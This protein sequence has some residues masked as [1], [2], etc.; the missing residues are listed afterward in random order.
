MFV[1]VV[2][3]MTLIRPEEQRAT[4]V[5]FVMVFLLMASYFVLRPVRDAM[6]SDW[7]DA[8]V[9]LLWNIQFFLSAGL[10]TLYSLMVSRLAFRWVVPAV[11]GGFAASFFLFFLATPRLADPTLAEKAFY[12][13]VAAFSLFNL[14]VFWSFMAD[15]FRREQGQRLFAII[16]AGASAGA[17]AGPSIPAL[18]A[19]SLGIDALMLIASLGLLLVI[20]LI[21]Y[22][23]RLKPT[24]LGNRSMRADLA[25]Q[26]IGGQWW[27]GFRDVVQ[28]RYLL[29]IA[30]F[31]TLYVFI[32]SFVYF[33]QKNLLAAYSRPERA[34]ILGAIDWVVNTLTFVFAFFVTGRVVQRLGMAF[35][36]AVVPVIV[37]IGLLVLAFAPI[38]MVL[39]AL[40]VARR[41]GNYAVT[42]P[43]RELLFTEVS[44]DERFKA[45]A[46]IDVVVHRGGDA[47]SGSLFALLTEGMGFGLA[48][49]ALI[50]AAI[51]GIWS[52]LAL[53]LGRLFDQTG[54]VSDRPETDQDITTLG[55]AAPIPKP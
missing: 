4:A 17:I 39:L 30:V 38:I 35:T 8:E 49:V 51:A 34:Q 28:N 19:D 46:V 41:V 44:T 5:S 31:I 54:R 37:A 42:R 6:A 13:W 24:A 10:V 48:A 21:F 12:L 32:G 53:F 11:Y 26:R 45:K 15:T 27:S 7:G 47:V 2:E 33:E 29:A 3:Q 22:L 1:R 23:Q 25:C 43:A 20:P 14:S 18:Y 52:A 40:Q 50:G 9:S 55:M 36:L 16:G